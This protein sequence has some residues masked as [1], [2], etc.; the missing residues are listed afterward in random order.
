MATLTVEFGK[1]NRFEERSV[2]LL[3]CHGNRKRRIPTE[4]A[5][6]ASEITKTGRIK[7]AAKARAVDKLLSTYKERIWEL[8]M[9]ITEEN[10]TAE[11]IVS[12][13]TG[14]GDAT[15]FFAF[16]DEWVTRSKRAGA[17]NYRVMLNVLERY[18]GERRLPFQ[19]ITYEF[20]TGFKEALEDRPRA[21]SLY[22]GEIRH[23]F[24]EAM[25]R[26]NTAF[27]R[28][29]GDDPFLR[30]T[31]PRQ[32]MRRGVRALSLDEL[33]RV[34][35]Y[36]GRRGS[37]AALARDCF[38]LSFCLMGMNS[39][40]MFEV[41]EMRNGRICYCRRKTRTRR[42]D[43]AYIEVCVHGFLR[44]LMRR[45]ADRGRVFN[46]HRRYSTYGGFNQALN[47]GLKVVGEAVGVPGLQ[48]YQA[49]HTFATLSRNLMRFAKSDVDEAL[50]HVGTMGIADIYIAKDFSII[51][52]NN[53]RLIERVFGLD[54]ERL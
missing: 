22:L 15:D 48:F 27:R 3:L 39:A 34:W 30:F 20:L 46:F 49:R 28:V 26:Y 11:D 32:V 25:R 21:Q 52:E 33:L 18:V 2:A 35:R 1:P 16:A 50:N 53:A 47:R 43:G 6:T 37:V 19:R 13:I 45:Y 40:D 36:E 9:A 8:S 38:I 23:L 29:I 12:R 7:N 54:G 14:T 51:N 24:R 42:D 44:P 17:K 31:V 10:L 5:L 41:E 4:I